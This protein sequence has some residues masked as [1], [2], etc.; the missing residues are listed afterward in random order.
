MIIR[1]KGKKFYAVIRKD[2]HEKWFGGETI[3]EAINNINKNYNVSNYINYYLNNIIVREN[4]KNF[5]HYALKS[6][7]NL[8]GKKQLKQLTTID[9]QNWISTINGTDRTKKDYYSAV[10]TA[11]KQALAWNLIDN[12]IWNGVIIPKPPRTTGKTYTLEQVKILIDKSKDTELYLFILLGIFCGM[13]ISEICGLRKN[14]IK[15]DC[16][17]IDAQLQ[18]TA[19]YN[20]NEL[21]KVPTK[22]KTKYALKPPK[23]PRSASKIACPYIVLQAIKNQRKNEDLYNTGLL[24][25]NKNHRPYEASYI[26]KHFKAFCIKNNL[27]CLR[28]HDLRHTSATLLLEAGVDPLTVS[29]QLRHSDVSTTQNIYQHL[30]EKI[31]KQPAEIFDRLFIPNGQVGNQVGTDFKDWSGRRDSNSRPLVPETSNKNETPL[32]TW[33]LLICGIKFFILNRFNL[34]FLYWTSGKK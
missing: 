13:R 17:I 32:D 4:T 26:R 6:L 25:L 9:L 30:S 24:L 5:Y 7:C 28:L 8:Y 31:K 3:E 29:N 18:R 14:R 12:K 22:S 20:E 23:T 2:G 10:R 34:Y 1:H 33:I 21:L 27:P 15:N 16:I 19:N 11:L